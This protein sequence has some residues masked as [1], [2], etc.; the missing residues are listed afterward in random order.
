MKTTKRFLA[1]ACFLMLLLSLTAAQAMFSDT[2]GPT[3]FA[4]DDM[5]VNELKLYTTKDEALRMFGAADSVESFTW[6][7]TGEK[8][9][10]W[11][12]EDLT[13]TFNSEGEVISA[14]VYG[15][16]YTGPRGVTVGQTPQEVAEKFYRDPNPKSSS[17]LYVT[18]IIESLEMY[19]PPYGVVVRHEDGTFSIDY[20]APLAPFSE[21]VLADPA[22]FVF[23]ELARFTVNFGAD[24]TV[25]DFSWQAGPWAE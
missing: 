23:E 20:A 1:A 15:K 4:P 13:L 2:F 14:L 7:A 21:E 17:E 6:G 9:E 22:S 19:L 3:I 12:Y 8:L 16:Q 11:H 5:S 10:M 25:T 24:M 18:S